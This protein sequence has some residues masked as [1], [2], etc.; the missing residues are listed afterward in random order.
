MFGR[1]KPIVFKPVPY[2]RQRQAWRPP[3]WLLLL[4]LGTG[5]GAG[6]LWYSQ[7]TYLPKRLS[8]LDSMKLEADMKTAI[9]ERDKSRA[10]LKAATEKMDK[11]LAD[12][13]KAQTDL[14]T[15]LVTTNRLQKDLSQFVLA[16]PP[17]PRGG[18]I[19]IRAGSFSPAAGQLAYNVIFTRPSKGNVFRG[20]MQLIVSGQKAGGL[21]ATAQ[22]QPV[23][24][25]LDGYQQLSGTLALPDGMV[26]R[27]VTVRVL[28]AAGG[29]MVSMR[30][31][32]LG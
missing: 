8:V 4:L 28:R 27:E 15:A 16:L 11:A 30:V 13:K 9:V 31:Y 1:S 32:R 7:E 24:M 29:D 25:E 3:K 22:L 21:N 23:V 14:A 6:G 2:Q 20:V 17:D 12:S 5:I 18:E 19:G 10:D 26:A